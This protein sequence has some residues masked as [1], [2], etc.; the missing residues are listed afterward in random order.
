MNKKILK[1][2]SGPL[3]NFLLNELVEKKESKMR[4][5][6]S[7]K[8]NTINKGIVMSGKAPNIKLIDPNALS[9]VKV[10][11]SG[12]AINNINLIKDS[13]SESIATAE[14]ENDTDIDSPN[15][16]PI[17]KPVKKSFPKMPTI[18]ADE[19]R[20]FTNNKKQKP[21]IAKEE[22]EE[23]SED[24][25]DTDD[26][27]E[28]ESISV[29]SSVASVKQKKMSSRETEQ[30]KQELLIKLLA[31]EK[32][33]VNLT[34]SYSLKSS[35]EE[36][37]FEYNTQQKAMEIEASV[38]F[39][40]KVLMAAVT[41]VEFLNNKFDPINA[42]L[43]GWSE[44]VMDNINDYE[45]IFRKLH[46]KYSQ[47]STM[48][49]ELQLLVTLVG[50]GFMFHLTNSL[51]KSSLPGLGDVLKT[52]P[53]IMGNIMGAM[54]KA[55]NNAHGITPGSNTNIPQQQVPQMPQVPQTVSTQM[56]KMPQVP[57]T[58]ST[59]MPKMPDFTG[60]SVNLSSLLNTYES[61]P[62]Q[63][64]MQQAPKMKESYNSDEN[65]RF[66]VAS[67][68]DYSEIDVSTKTVTLPNSKGKKQKGKSIT[69]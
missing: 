18:D 26:E 43:D 29:A 53:D 40:Q 46:E 1:E 27:S 36:I 17:K 64:M 54:G 34:K 32:K 6:K 55:M 25:S 52:N 59:Q 7:K 20:Y 9:T 60:P 61:G 23:E 19:F 24:D 66:S 35:L 47:K 41:G 67:S 45:E 44:S 63:P 3:S 4:F 56:P 15:N 42:K 22:S 31:L 48:P 39:Q 8:N 37:E 11:N 69:I 58:V 49:P 14:P 62:P 38:H 68:S 13:D 57:Q 30:K 65:D 50:S 33:G 21:I 51:F 28:A 10:K 5:D 12:S 16:T 2:S